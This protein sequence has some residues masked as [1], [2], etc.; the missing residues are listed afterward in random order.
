MTGGA[1][2]ADAR[3][4]LLLTPTDQLQPAVKA[5]MDRDQPSQTLLLGGPSALTR[6]VEQA[7]PSPLRVAGAARDETATSV[8]RTLWKVEPSG[9]RRYTAINGYATDGWAW[10]LA[11]A[12]LADRAEAPLLMVHPDTVP[13]A[14]TQTVSGCRQI[15]LLLVGDTRSISQARVDELDARDNRC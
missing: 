2:A 15:D 5:W 7:V 4:P 9:T 8:A 6:R 13:S 10:G 14:T 11:T 1:F 3:I 12:G